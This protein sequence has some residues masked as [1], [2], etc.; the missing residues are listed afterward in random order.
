MEVVIILSSWKLL[1]LKE[2]FILASDK[3]FHD[4]KGVE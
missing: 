4:L 1:Q 3:Q 2:T